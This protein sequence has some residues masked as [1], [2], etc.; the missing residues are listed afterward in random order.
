MIIVSYGMEM[1]RKYEAFAG[2]VILFTM[3][4]LAIW[5][6]NNADWTIAWS[7]PTR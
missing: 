3:I 1:I 7:R 5:M 2:P 4:A 6:L